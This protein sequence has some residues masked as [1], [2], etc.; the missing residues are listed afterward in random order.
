VGPKGVRAHE[1]PTG[2]GTDA[3][4]V[5]QNASGPCRFAFVTFLRVQLHHGRPACWV[6]YEQ[7]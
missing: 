4:S 3:E 2:T 6:F 5:P 1:T 7:A